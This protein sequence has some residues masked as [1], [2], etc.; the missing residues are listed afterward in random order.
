MNMKFRCL[1]SVFIFLTHMPLAHAALEWS[2]CAE[3]TAKYCPEMALGSDQ[4]AQCLA[5]LVD[6]SPNGDQ[7][8][9]SACHSTI[10]HWQ[11]HS[12]CKSDIETLCSNVPT[13]EHRIHNCMKENANKT[14]KACSEFIRD[15]LT[16]LEPQTS[17]LE[18]SC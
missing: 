7:R 10:R 5:K 17:R 3:E 16:L 4:A 12:V 2:R 15:N 11:F 8:L 18:L 13:G 9:T 6:I 1:L 14:N